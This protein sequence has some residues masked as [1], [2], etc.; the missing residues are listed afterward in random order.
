MINPGLTQTSFWKALF[1]VFSNLFCSSWLPRVGLLPWWDSLAAYDSRFWS[2]VVN[3]ELFAIESFRLRV[4]DFSQFASSL[5]VSQ[6]SLRD[7]PLYL[8]HENSHLLPVRKQTSQPPGDFRHVLWLLFGSFSSS[9]NFTPILI[10]LRRCWFGQTREVFFLV[11][12]VAWPRARVVGWPVRVRFWNDRLNRA[13][14]N[15]VFWVLSQWKEN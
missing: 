6:G 1:A 7:P 15:P 4:C 10:D 5:L 3:C 11:S 8:G 9:L 12:D 14:T 13:W 2:I